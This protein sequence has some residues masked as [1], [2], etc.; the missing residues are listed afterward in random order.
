LLNLVLM[1]KFHCFTIVKAGSV[2]YKN[3]GSD[4]WSSYSKIFVIVVSFV[5]Y[6]P[7]TR[8][9]WGHRRRLLPRSEKAHSGSTLRWNPAF[10]VGRTHWRRPAAEGPVLPCSGR[11]DPGRVHCGGGAN[12]RFPGVVYK[13]RE[14][15][16]FLPGNSKRSRWEIEKYG[17]RDC[18]P[19]LEERG[20]VLKAAVFIGFVCFFL[21]FCL[22]STD[23][24]LA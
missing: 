1:V 9:R 20:V 14:D 21:L 6:R 15:L 11:G 22:C 13:G 2:D 4:G 17:R 8:F 19:S 23:S 10:R 16:P 7:Q 5:R 3:P 18:L 12:P 24:R